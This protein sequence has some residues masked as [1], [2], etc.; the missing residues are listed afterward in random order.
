[1]SAF[2]EFDIELCNLLRHNGRATTTWL[3]KTMGCTRKKVAVRKARLEKKGVIQGYFPL[4]NCAITDWGFFALIALR[5]ALPITDQ[6]IRK[7]LGFEDI[8]QVIQ[9]D[10]DY[11]LNLFGW[12][13]SAKRLQNF[14][15]SK[16]KPIP[17]VEHHYTQILLR[18]FFYGELAVG[19]TG[20]PTILS[21]ELD[22]LDYKIA[23]ILFKNSR[24]SIVDIAKR[25][26]VSNQTVLNRVNRMIKEKVIR[27]FYTAIDTTK[28]EKS[29]KVMIYIVIAPKKFKKALEAI[30]KL[31][32]LAWVTETTGKSDLLI[33]IDFQHI[34]ELWRYIHNKLAKI[35]GV[36][37]TESYLVTGD[38]Y[39]K[40]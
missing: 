7:I 19:N 30:V 8:V 22:E 40:G 4:V 32:P 33:S 24:T 28:L 26:K 6:I 34:E 1:M 17:G 16:I 9:I 10:G 3:A 31:K 21:I 25:L 13:K 27:K 29:I 11:N 35:D 36:L 14:L 20:N 15:S 18:S 2:D 38:Y 39:S 5:V 23:R 12:F 37:K